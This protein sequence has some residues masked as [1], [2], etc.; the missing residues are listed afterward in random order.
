MNFH[1]EKA[2]IG[3]QFRRGNFLRECGSSLGKALARSGF[4]VS[5]PKVAVI[6]VD[7]PGR[8]VS[9]PKGICVQWR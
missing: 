1:L 8:D 7:T 5:S 2:A 4:C 3:F 6:N 9:G